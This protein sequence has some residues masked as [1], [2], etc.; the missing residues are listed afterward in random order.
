MSEEPKSKR[1]KHST[2]GAPDRT[3]CM[4]R[5]LRKEMSLPEIL[6]WQQLQQ[7]PGG[8]LFRKQHPIG[9]Y[10]LDF[11]CVKA[12]LAIEVDGESHSRGDRPERDAIRDAW[13]LAQGFDTIR[14][15][16]AEV[17]KNMESVLLTIVA[18]CRKRAHP[19]PPRNG[20]V[21]RRRRDGGAGSGRAQTFKLGI[22]GER[23]LRPLEGAPP[24][25]GEDL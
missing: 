8:Y 19:T 18:E 22:S 2:L 20:E 10:A 6:L 5:R 11:C 9:P 24:R 14:F 13:V 4:A 16:A 3:I 25:S 17:L 23:P 1:K 21:A 12:K 15:A 7:H